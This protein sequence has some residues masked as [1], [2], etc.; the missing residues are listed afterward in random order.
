MWETGVGDSNEEQRQQVVMISRGP[1]NA[2]MSASSK[3]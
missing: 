1:I 3:R 2:T